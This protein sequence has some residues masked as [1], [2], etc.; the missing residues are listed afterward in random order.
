MHFNF[1][2]HGRPFAWR[3]AQRDRR[4]GRTFTDKEMVA[5][6]R[7]IAARACEAWGNAPP[8]FG[9]VKLLVMA[10]FE[11]P[12]SWPRAIREAAQ[13]GEVYCDSKPD[14]DNI[15]KQIADALQFVA[16]VD[17]CQIADGRCILRYGTGER[18]EVWAEELAGPQTPAQRRR[19][20][21]WLEGA[22][23][24]A[25]AKAPCGRARWPCVLYA[26]HIPPEP[27]QKGLP[28]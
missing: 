2:I 6:Q 14:D 19:A 16:F 18:T 8:F 15:R 13:R 23:D 22:Y 3:R 26:N 5:S 27:A 20:K 7:A 4:S 17:D 28:L 21:A 9:P 12:T 25:I 10:V 1:T 24:A 11:I